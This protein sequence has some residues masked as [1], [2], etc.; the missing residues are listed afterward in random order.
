VALYRV[1]QESLGRTR[2]GDGP[3]LVEC[4]RWRIEGKRGVTDDPLIH[5]QEFLRE[6]KIATSA[7]FEN[8]N[9]SARK[10]LTAKSGA[11]KKR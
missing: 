4:V 7:W 10:R 1:T 11:S 2:G 3:V 6:R 9:D 8:A 5:L